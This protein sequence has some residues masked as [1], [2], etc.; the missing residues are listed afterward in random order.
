MLKNKRFVIF[1]II[2]FVQLVLYCY[3]AK[4]ADS[5]TPP[6]HIHAMENADTFYPD[7]I[8]QSIHGAWNYRYSYSTL[9]AQKIYTFLFFIAAG[10]IA[11]I[12]HIDPIF[13]YEITRITGGAAIL[14][15]TYW[16]I[17]LLL[18]SALQIPAMIF[19]MVFDTG[20]FWSDVIHLPIWKWSAAH[21]ELIMIARR[22]WLP[23][24]LWS[25][26]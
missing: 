11:A 14:V 18:P 9:P 3:L 12:F 10:K 4:R 21:P 7:I 1:L 2:L 15:A 8:R 17:T 23:H 22:F 16:F 19:T 5:I 6:G 24:H 20:P 25:V 13:M 26:R